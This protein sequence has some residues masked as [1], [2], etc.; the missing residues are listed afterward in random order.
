[1]NAIVDVDDNARRP[2]KPVTRFASLVSHVATHHAQH[3]Q[4]EAELWRTVDRIADMAQSNELRV[5]RIERMQ[6]LI[7]LVGIAE[8]V[9]F[10][11]CR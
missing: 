1:M 3:V 9:S 5:K 2:S 4:S 7:L 10:F 11:V 8:C 6:W